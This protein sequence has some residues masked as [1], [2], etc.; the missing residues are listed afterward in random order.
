MVDPEA[1][2]HWPKRERGEGRERGEAI[3][4]QCKTV[5]SASNA[6]VDH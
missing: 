6:R 5:N 1:R 3:G 2:G 4:V